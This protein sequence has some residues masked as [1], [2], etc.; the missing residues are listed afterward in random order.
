MPSSP[1]LVVFSHLRWDFVF[2]RPQHLLT[3]LARSR[4]VLFV[5]EPV[6][7]P[8]GPPRWE[9]SQ[10]APGVTVCRPRTPVSEHGFTDA[11]NAALAPLVRELVAGRVGPAYDLWFYTPMALPLAEGLSPRVVVYDC[12]DDLSAF[13]NAPPAL[14]EREEQLLARA[15]VVFTGGPSLFEA[16][17]DRHPNA[18][19]F[20]SSVDAAHFGRAAAGDVIEPEDQHHLP[21][22]RLGYYGVIDERIDLNLL[23]AVA[24]ARPSW[25]LVMVGPV[26]KVDPADLPRRENIHYLGQKRYEELP[27]YLSGWDVA[28]MP[29]ARNDATR[30]IS[31]TKVLEY[32][33]G[34]V[35]VV[36]TRIADVAGPYGDMVGLGD[37][38]EEFVLAC[39]A[40]LAEHEDARGKR[41]GQFDAVLAKTSW[42]A[43]AAAME[44]EI[45]KA[46]SGRAGVGPV[47]G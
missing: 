37:A 17:R 46:V 25:Q 28:L 23:A 9:I 11:Q 30:R 45:G 31:P 3:R 42:E 5:E 27:A 34:G 38:A 26:A 6:P 19:C 35:P 39:E 36:S 1:A 15:G 12:M 16:M 41:L 8:D 20:P 4:P 24:D 47:P 13:K 29:F 2:Q 33:A 22:P 14:K 40:A 7:D 43:T 21:R 44:A 18:H 32:M 10:P